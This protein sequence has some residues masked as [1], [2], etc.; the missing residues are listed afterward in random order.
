MKRVIENSSSGNK[1]QT[2][3]LTTPKHVRSINLNKFQTN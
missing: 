2:V 3:K 1:K